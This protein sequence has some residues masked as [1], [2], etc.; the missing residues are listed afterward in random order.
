MPADHSDLLEQLLKQTSK[1]EQH[2]P[3]ELS[4]TR[5]QLQQQQMVAEEADDNRPRAESQKSSTEE[6]GSKT[7]VKL[8]QEEMEKEKGNTDKTVQDSK[9][10]EISVVG[11]KSVKEIE[12]LMDHIKESLKELAE[13]TDQKRKEFSQ[14]TE[15]I[16]KQIANFMFQKSRASS[17]NMFHL[18]WQMANDLETLGSPSD[19]ASMS[20]KEFKQKVIDM[21]KEKWMPRN[22]EY[23]QN[24]LQSLQRQMAAQCESSVRSLIE[25]V[26]AAIR[27]NMDRSL[28]LVDQLKNIII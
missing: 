26:I 13:K 9:A 16:P 11:L 24:C 19:I 17:Q 22:K 5:I 1:R 27:H 2:L 21:V 23:L 7:F 10:G 6:M 8:E 4:E 18:R 20:R 15:E 25:D 14:K 28:E 12:F 3:H